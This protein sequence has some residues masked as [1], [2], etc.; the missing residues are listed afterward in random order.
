M[1]NLL[2]QNKELKRLKKE[3]ERRRL[4]DDEERGVEDAEKK[5]RDLDEFERVQAGLRGQS[6]ASTQNGTESIS[7]GV[8]RK[9]ANEDDSSRQEDEQGN[10]NKRRF[11]KHARQTKGQ[12]D[13]I[14]G[15]R[16]PPKTPFSP[17]ACRRYI[18]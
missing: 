6:V 3:A 4:E 14:G 10:K 18:P 15:Q 11:R 12:K 16:N 17:T 8:K 1:S 13:E 2:A 7:K 9:L 5:A